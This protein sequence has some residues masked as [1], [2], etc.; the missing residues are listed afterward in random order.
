MSEPIEWLPNGTPYSP[1]FGD[2]YHS[3]NDHGLTQ[4]R[5]CFLAG[6]GL[7]TAW[8]GQPRWRILETGFGLGLNFL[9]AWAAWR[10]D[11]QRPQV[12]HF[13]SVEAFPASDQDILRATLRIPQATELYPLAKQLAERFHGLLPGV[14]RLS[15]EDG[16]VM[17]TLW[18]GDA[19]AQLRQQS[20]VADSIYLDGFSPSVNPDIWSIHTIKALARHCRRG[21]QLATWSVARSVREHL[22]QCGFEVNKVSGVPPKRHNLQATFNPAWQQRKRA[23]HVPAPHETVGSAVVVGAGLAGSA[24]AYSLALRGWQVTVLAAGTAPADAASGLPAGLFCTQVSPDD[25][26]LARLTRCGVQ[27]TLQRLRDLQHLCQPGIDWK[28]SGVLEHCTSGS[29]SYPH[30]WLLHGAGAYWSTA[31]TA[32]QLAQAGLPAQTAARWHAQAGW[33][34][35]AQLVQAQLQHRHIRF[36]GSASVTRLHTTDTQSDTPCWHALDAA[37][38]PLATGD[39]AII[40]AGA[41]T[42]NLLPSNVRWPLQMIRGQ[43]SCDSTYASGQA[44]AAQLPPFPVNGHGNFVG[45][46][47]GWIMG[48]TFERGVNALPASAK[49]QRL[50][51]AANF[52][53]LQTL[54]PT[55]SEALSPWFD[56]Q[57]ARCQSTWGQIRCASHDRLPIVGAVSDDTHRGL[58][59][60]CALGARGLTLSVLCG[61]W[62][63]AQLHA[64]PAPFET[65]LAQHL[66][67]SRLHRKTR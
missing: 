11:P 14:H 66:S 12:L 5:C 65:R 67:V 41:G 23:L 59:T 13:T 21:T 48:S 31:A 49:D 45:Q 19:Q 3:E 55:H 37:G 20:T 54:L 53:K 40:A 50:A 17:L 2:R 35:P 44:R 30:D 26:I 58:W 63:A 57:D 60:V 33:V 24:V 47:T 25:N 38:Q 22:S 32:T 43:V 39:I 51:H 18:I 36:M 1:R 56:P 9:V 46:S 42:P 10:A 61:E 16:R 6:C 4:A 27:L 15:F 8:A 28:H 34:R 52:R 62:L 29:G 64:E 7:P